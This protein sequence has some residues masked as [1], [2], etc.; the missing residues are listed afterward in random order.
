[1]V[2]NF[3]RLLCKFQSDGLNYQTVLIQ[4]LE[5]FHNATLTCHYLIGEIWYRAGQRFVVDYL[6]E[7]QKRQRETMLTKSIRLVL[8]VSVLGPKTAPP[9]KKPEFKMHLLLFQANKKT[10]R[11]Q[12]YKKI[13]DQLRLRRKKKEI[14]GIKIKKATLIYQTEG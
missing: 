4:G 3:N 14:K 10:W 7:Q 12:R 6:I 9:P 11:I 2:F 13:T 1:M 5:S 8:C